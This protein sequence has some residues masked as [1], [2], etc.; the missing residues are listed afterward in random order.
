LGPAAITLLLIAAV[1]GFAALAWR[2]ISIVVALRPEVRWDRPL[3]RLRTVAI[4][5]FMQSRMVRRE[6]KPGLMHAVI[7]TGFVTLLVRKIELLAIGYREHFAYGGSFGDIFAFSKDL[8]ELAVLAAVAYALWR[9]YV[10]K[11]VRLERNREALAILSLIAAI[12]ITDLAFDAFRF[13][14]LAPVDPAIARE[15]SFAFAGSALAA[16][17]SGVP[18]AVLRAGMRLLARHQHGEDALAH[19]P[20]LVQFDAAVEPQKPGL[21]NLLVLRLEVRV[22]DADALVVAEVV[23]CA[24][25]RAFP[26]GEMRVVVDDH[27]ALRRDVRPERPDGGDEAR[28]AVVPGVADERLDRVG[29][30]HCGARR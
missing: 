30:R 19:R 4:N 15:A 21:E 7:F 12:M 8:V 2:K 16:V 1:A 24:A 5:G 20:V 6:W 9:R 29:Q 10:Q 18:D 14:R 25:L 13:A 3:A 17:W 28:I 27:A 26:P 22:D 23:E 11:P